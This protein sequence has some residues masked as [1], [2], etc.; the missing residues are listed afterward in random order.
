MRQLMLPFAPMVLLGACAGGLP[1]PVV[2]VALQP[3]DA[4]R[5]HAW[6]APMHPTERRLL[7]FKWQFLD[8]RG[9][10]AGGS[11]SAQIAAPDSLRFDYRGPLGSGRGAAVVVDDSALWAQPEDQVKKLVPNYPLLWAMLGVT[12]APQRGDVLSGIDNAELTAWRYVHG[13]D[14]VDYAR[15]KGKSPQLVADVREGGK[16]VGRVVTTFDA[17]GHPIKSQ[18]D[19]PSGPVRLTLKFTLVSLPKSFDP[20]IWHAPRDN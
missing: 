5:V 6:N 18:L 11:G 13:A 10:T 1:G 16:R 17:Q 14:T 19:V 3:V 9:A 4:G 2:P 12:R 20:E 15:S 7:R 8:E